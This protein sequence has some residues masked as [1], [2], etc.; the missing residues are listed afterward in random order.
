MAQPS[1]TTEEFD[2]G[3]GITQAMYDVVSQNMARIGAIS[4]QQYLYGDSIPGPNTNAPSPPPVPVPSPVAP[5][6]TARL[7]ESTHLSAIARLNQACQR[8][9]GTTDVLRYEFI[10]E[11]GQKSKQCILTITRPDGTKRSYAT[12][13]AFAKKAEAKA[14]ASRIAID[15]DAL[16]FITFGETSSSSTPSSGPSND[17]GLSPPGQRDD[18]SSS[19]SIIEKCCVQ[20]RPASIT[21][22]WVAFTDSKLSSKYGFALQ[23]QLSPHVERVYMSQPICDTYEEAKEACAKAAI[24]EGVLNFIKHGNG[25]VR[26]PSPKP[27]PDSPTNER[28]GQ[29]SNSTAPLALQTFFDS[30]PRPFPE[31]FDS[32]DAHKINAPGWLHSL[33]QSARGGKLGMSYFFT[34]G[35]TPGLHGCLLRIDQP[36]NYKAYLVEAQ[37]AKRADAKAAVTLRAMSRG[38]GDYIRTIASSV[39]LKVTPQMR[40]FSSNYVFPTLQSEL[41]KIDPALHPQVEYGKQK[42]AFGATLIVALPTVSTLPEMRKYEVPCE[43]RNKA[44]ARVAVIAQAAEQG[45]IEFVRFRGRP[46]PAGYSSPFI[47]RNYDPDASRKRLQPDNPEESQPSKKQKKDLPRELDHRRS[48]DV[49]GE[50][51]LGGGHPQDVSEHWPLNTL[52]FPGY[53]SD[54]GSG[55][56]HPQQPIVH[57]GHPPHGT[58][59]ILGPSPLHFDPRPRV[60]NNMAG[61]ASFSGSDHFKLPGMHSAPSFPYPA[62]Q[63]EP[64]NVPIPMLVNTQTL[65]FPSKRRRD[66]DLE[67]GEVFS[68]SSS[69]SSQSDVPSQ[70]EGRAGD[71]GVHHD[72]SQK[73]ATNTPAPSEE[74]TGKA[75]NEATK[76]HVKALIEYCV[77]NGLGPPSIGEERSETNMFKAWI[78]IGKER[79]ELPRMYRTAE[80]GKQRVAKQ[81]LARLRS[82]RK[83]EDG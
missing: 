26:P 30:L 23:I 73:P 15:M 47:L 48:L 18:G 2:D 46:P 71:G 51:C 54:L 77:K 59:L 35:T 52:P 25:Q 74:R 7:T 31:K 19:V 12:Q 39:E 56:G 36:E 70:P 65:P 37:F 24:A 60:H 22:H 9:F 6:S 82:Q 69:Q 61:P 64:S 29:S 75:R 34:S 28:D 80:E 8:A 16:D 43:Y 68:P 5:A 32:N 27:L 58:P 38:V 42:D 76:S 57:G 17:V 53:P 62:I 83:A 20:W 13:P 14:E 33:I 3:W 10:E 44:D 50:E 40:S 45:V 49:T 63:H 81:V 11:N 4:M 67:P 79:F 55:Y 78:V 66:S 21:P 41:N 1:T 72:T